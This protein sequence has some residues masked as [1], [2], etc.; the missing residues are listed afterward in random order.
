M[1]ELVPVPSWR[2]ALV[3]G[4]CETVSSEC[5]IYEHGSGRPES[6]SR[7]SGMC[8]VECCTVVGQLFPC[9]IM[10]AFINTHGAY[11]DPRLRIDP[12]ISLPCHGHGRRRRRM[13]SARSMLRV[14][15]S[16]AASPPLPAEGFYTLMDVHGDD[17]EGWS[18][19]REG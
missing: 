14:L 12:V 5:D 17:S 10:F 4:V 2:V 6:T 18:A 19:C 8:V 11:T 15:E 3:Y 16:Y 1:R 13:G 9:Y 7:R